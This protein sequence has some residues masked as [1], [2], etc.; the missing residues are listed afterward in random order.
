MATPPPSFFAVEFELDDPAAADQLNHDDFPGLRRV[1]I[2]AV[3]GRR[4]LLAVWA[5]EEAYAASEAAF[6]GQL[7]T[8]G[9]PADPIWRGALCGHLY[10]RGGKRGTRN[11]FLRLRELAGSRDS[12][13]FVAEFVVESRFDLADLK[14]PDWKGLLYAQVLVG[15]TECR[16]LTFWVDESAFLAVKALFAPRNSLI[17]NVPQ[18]SWTGLYRDARGSKTWSW[19]GLLT[20][21]WA[22]AATVFVILGYF[23]KL[24][25][26]I[27]W[28][29]LPAEAVVADPDKPVEDVQQGEDLTASVDVLNSRS[30]GT[31]D[32]HFQS[33]TFEPVG[34]S[35]ADGLRQLHLDITEY[36][37]LK[38][39][40]KHTFKL[41]G[42]AAKPGLYGVS[43][44]GS[45]SSGYFFSARKLAARRQVRVWAPWQ[46]DHRQLVRWNKHYG[47]VE[48]GLRIGRALPLGLEADALLTREPG[49]RFQAVISPHVQRADLP[50]E[51]N[52]KGA[53]VTEIHWWFDSLEGLKLITFTLE[54]GSDAE[55]SR[56][57][58]E[59]IAD[60]L[61]FDFQP[62][63][64][65][66]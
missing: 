28:L 50:E 35:P 43:L 30:L 42:K 60:R 6:L 56:E 23:E 33:P 8:P 5:G 3:D 16:L 11:S 26:G 22:A 46:L 59:Q 55:Q 36:G 20:T 1:L 58:W 21:L 27:A 49:V 41:L 40:D 17:A 57:S 24:R 65:K 44:L 37:G 63:R 52:T 14:V 15:P 19:K 51:V 53:E 66:K 29:V 12:V 38:S 62:A 64:P 32:I 9:V 47:V 48:L 7:G 13:P 54:L 4:R 2:F 61:A 25:D 39:G 31:C 18:P 34:G 10:P 45:S